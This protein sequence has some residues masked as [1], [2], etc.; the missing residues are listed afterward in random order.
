M[1]VIWKLNNVIVYI[2]A[3]KMLKKVAV[4]KDLCFKNTHNVKNE[5]LH[6][7]NLK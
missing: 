5:H 3:F 7:S 1:K 4:L 2:I 6:C